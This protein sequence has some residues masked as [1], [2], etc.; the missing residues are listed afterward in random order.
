MDLALM[1]LKYFFSKNKRRYGQ[2]YAQ[3]DDGDLMERRHIG[4]KALIFVHA[5]LMELRHGLPDQDQ[6]IAHEENAE[7]H[8]GRG[9]KQ[10]IEVLP[11]GGEEQ[12][13]RDDQTHG[14]FEDP[15]VKGIGADQHRLERLDLSGGAHHPG[16]DLPGDQEQHDGYH[17]GAELGDD[18]Q[19]AHNLTVHFLVRDLI[20]EPRE[21]YDRGAAG[22]QRGGDEVNR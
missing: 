4:E 8:H 20:P 13:K 3:N 6:V 11:L 7:H 10:G 12:C 22:H 1:T 16:D 14:D 21:E 15:E 5:E 17:Q 18:F 2:R 19:G 9:R